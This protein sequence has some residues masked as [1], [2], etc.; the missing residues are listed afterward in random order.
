MPRKT[1]FNASKAAKVKAEKSKALAIEHEVQ[2]A[3]APKTSW[4]MGVSRETFRKRLEKEMPRI[5]KSRVVVVTAESGST[6][7]QAFVNKVRQHPVMGWAPQ[8][9]GAE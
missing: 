5:I 8:R 7:R 1:P 3:N 4:W 6:A 9:S 2:A